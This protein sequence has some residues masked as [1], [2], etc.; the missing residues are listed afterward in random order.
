MIASFGMYDPPWLQPFNDRLWRA[1][2][3]RLETAPAQLCRNR[4]LDDI[5]TD[6]SLLLAQT[7]GYPLTTKLG[8]AVTLVATPTYRADGCEGAWHRSAI[9]VRSDDRAD[10]LAALRGRVAAINAQDSNT[11][12][13]LLRAAIAPIARAQRFFSSV[14]TTGAHA[15]SVWAVIGHRADCA[16]ID[17]ITLAL[18]R[19]RFPRLDQRI[20]VLGWTA[21]SPGLPM[22]T[23]HGQDSDALRKALASVMEDPALAATR[24]ALRLTGMALLDRSAYDVVTRLELEAI[25]AGYPVLA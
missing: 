9:I 4:S 23:A 18:L 24:N 16:A 13:N 10:R 22:I 12:M 25:D 7:C 3:A 19:D 1:I 2:A 5:W 6:R 20:R 11:G 14:V 8:A 15:R 17:A 21:A